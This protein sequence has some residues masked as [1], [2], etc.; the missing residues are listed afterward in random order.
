MSEAI[1]W[2]ELPWCGS[3]W[4]GEV[5]LTAAADVAG[6]GAAAPGPFGLR[7]LLCL[8]GEPVT[9]CDRPPPDDVSAGGTSW[10]PPAPEGRV[11]EPPWLGLIWPCKG[12]M[13]PG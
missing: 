7:P 10:L 2:A 8:D 13:L 4:P 9:M 6:A 1:V 3:R 5:E 11:P 12:A